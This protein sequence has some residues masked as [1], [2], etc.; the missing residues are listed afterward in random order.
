MD[1]HTA[2]RPLLHNVDVIFNA[3]KH[4]IRKEQITSILAHLNENEI[5]SWPDPIFQQARKIVWEHN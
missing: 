5:G 3:I 2:S 4:S 1:I